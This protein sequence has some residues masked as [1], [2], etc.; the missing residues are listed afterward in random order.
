MSSYHDPEADNHLTF[1]YKRRSEMAETEV[2]ILKARIEELE[3][4]VEAA[5]EYW[6]DPSRQ[7]SANPDSPVVKAVA[8]AL[9]ALDSSESTPER[10][11]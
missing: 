1:H 5:R 11:E 6:A 3:R 9:A 7:A 4:V 2:R 8:Q 10:N